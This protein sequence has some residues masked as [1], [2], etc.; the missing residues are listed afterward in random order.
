MAKNLPTNAGDPGDTGLIPGSERSSGE[1]NS[2]PGGLQS[3][4][5]QRADKTKRTRTLHLIATVSLNLGGKDP[6]VP[7]DTVKVYLY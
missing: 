5:L 6:L 3:R 1:G 2:K 7:P 4:G